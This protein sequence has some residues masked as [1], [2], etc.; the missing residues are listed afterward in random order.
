MSV[1]TQARLTDSTMLLQAAGGSNDDF[2]DLLRLF[3]SIFPAMV[4]RLE[5]FFADENMPEVAQ[6]AHDVKGCLYLVGAMRSAD[7]V[8]SIEVA[9]RHDRALCHGA[10]FEQLMD[11][12]R[13]VIDEIEGDL[14]S[15][16]MLSPEEMC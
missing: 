13:S 2:R 8:E 11:E 10:E 7:R 16:T 3:L 6:Q 4:D 5:L 14:N 9:A 15:A 12:M 1:K